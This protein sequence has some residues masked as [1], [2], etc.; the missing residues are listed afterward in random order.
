MNKQMTRLGQILT[1][2]ILSMLAPLLAA[3]KPNVVLIYTDD[4]GFGDVGCYGATKVRTPHIDRSSVQVQIV[5]GQVEAADRFAGKQDHQQ[6]RMRIL[7]VRAS[8][9]G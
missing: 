4:L 3:E 5:A 9:S 1:L 2:T 6:R 8:R 7:P